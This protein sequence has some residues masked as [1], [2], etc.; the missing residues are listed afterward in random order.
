M[1]QP[2]RELAK[3]GHEVVFTKDMDTETIEY[4]RDGSRFDVIVGQR[5]AGYDG[6]TTWR[7]SRTPRNRLVYETDDDLFSIEEINWAAHEQ[8]T[9]PKVQ[10]GIKTYTMMSDLVTTTTE[11][12]AQVQRD[13]GAEKVAVLPNC[14]PEYVLDLP[15]AVSG[16]RPRI[17]WVG[18]ASHGLD[19][20]EAVPGVRRFLSKNPEWDLYLAGTDYRPSFNA[21]NWDQMAHAGWRQ[22]NEDEHKYYE[23]IDFE[24]GIAPLKD[25]VF[26][27]SKSALKALEYNARGI[28]VIASSVQPYKEFVVHGENGFL[29][30]GQHEWLKYLRLLADNPDLRAEMGKK[31]KEYASRYTHEG[32]WQRWEAAYEG[33][34]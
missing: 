21:R 27:R 32:N 10:D 26:A 28:P 13:I 11:T 4:L 2:L 15:K 24:I 31:G 12:L 33:L 16:R 5:F 19:V 22:I 6:M 25:T 7:R 20:H 8:F 29:V 18:G 1:V 9:Q 14:V 17:G 30:K 23:L 3:H 34:F